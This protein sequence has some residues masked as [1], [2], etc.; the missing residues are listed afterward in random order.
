MESIGQNCGIIPLNLYTIL[1]VCICVLYKFSVRV[2]NE[3]K[4]AMQ[5]TVRPVLRR[6]VQFQRFGESS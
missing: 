4:Y 1:E 2:H 5:T 3:R 6:K